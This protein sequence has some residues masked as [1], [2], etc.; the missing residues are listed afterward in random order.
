MI[1]GSTLDLVKYGLRLWE[2]EIVGIGDLYLGSESKFDQS[3][4]LP[5]FT[6]TRR[7]SYAY[8]LF[9]FDSATWLA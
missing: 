4:R 7:P 8:L 6:I 3:V 2:G 1:E 5:L 9:G